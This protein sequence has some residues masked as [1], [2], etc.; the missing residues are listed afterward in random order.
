MFPLAVNV[1]SY[2]NAS[3]TSESTI[4]VVSNERQVEVTYF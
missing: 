2:Q 1:K 3:M 4:P